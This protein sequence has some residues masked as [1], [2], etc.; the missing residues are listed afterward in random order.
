VDSRRASEH[1]KIRIM[2]V[3]LF[4]EVLGPGLQG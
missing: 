2:K 3:S 1:R 4:A